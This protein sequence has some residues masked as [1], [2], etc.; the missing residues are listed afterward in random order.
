[1]TW[2]RRPVFILWGQLGTKILWDVVVCFY[3]VNYTFVC[4]ENTD[5]LATQGSG[6]YVNE[7]LPSRCLPFTIFQTRAGLFADLCCLANSTKRFCVL[8]GLFWSRHQTIAE[9]SWFIWIIGVQREASGFSIRLSLTSLMSDCKFFQNLTL[10]IYNQLLAG[11]HIF[12]A[13]LSPGRDQRVC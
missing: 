3:C 6:F 8:K 10:M 9:F 7:R 4:E 11:S 12:A 5:S 2:S 1:M 13:F